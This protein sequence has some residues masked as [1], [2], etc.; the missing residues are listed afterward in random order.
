MNTKP[1]A[2]EVWLA[3]LGMIAKTRP[4]LILAY[5]TPEHARMLIL[6]AP[7][8]SQIRNLSGEIYI[9]KPRWLPKESAVNIQALASISKPSLL[10]K[11][12]VLAKDKL[13]EVKEEIKLLLDL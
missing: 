1:K 4:V 11:M 7:L 2:G 8:T 5:P 9:G 3:D 13:D 6:V 12:G 10:R